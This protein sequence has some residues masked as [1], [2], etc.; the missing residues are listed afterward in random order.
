MVPTTD[1][2]ELPGLVQ[3]RFRL[4]GRIALVT[5]GGSGLGRASAVKFA[6]AGAHV[7]VVDIDASAAAETVALVDKAGFDATAYACDVS[8]VSDVNELMASIS[9]QHGRLDVLLNNAGTPGAP[10]LEISEH[11]WDRAVNV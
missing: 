1:R 10:G 7:S 8:S 2:D 5:G 3:D 6:A 4:D 11:D 9:Q